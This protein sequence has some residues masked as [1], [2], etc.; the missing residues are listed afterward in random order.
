MTGTLSAMRGTSGGMAEYLEHKAQQPAELWGM[1]A[2]VFYET[3]DRVA[4]QFPTQDPFAAFEE[5]ALPTPPTYLHQRKEGWKQRPGKVDRRTYAALIGLAFLNARSTFSREELPNY[6]SM[7]G[8]PGEE[9]AAAGIASAVLLNATEQAIL[10]G[11][12]EA[13]LHMA[14]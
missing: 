10:I 13:R 5:S 7:S 14:R 12:K 4:Q 1:Y 3:W 8:L 2:T 9:K 11:Y 6:L